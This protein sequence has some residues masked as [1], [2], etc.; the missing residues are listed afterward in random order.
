MTSNNDSGRYETC[1]RLPLRLFLF[2]NSVYPECLPGAA[3]NSQHPTPPH[4]TSLPRPSPEGFRRRHTPLS[5]LSCHSSMHLS[6]PPAG[7][8]TNIPFRRACV[9]NRPRDLPLRPSNPFAIDRASSKGPS[10]PTPLRSRAL[11]RPSWELHR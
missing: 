4:T 10:E 7:S 2:C 8:E 11:Q 3:D 9:P 5:P 6:P 1:L